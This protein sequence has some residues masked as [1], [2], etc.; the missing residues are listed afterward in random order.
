MSLFFFFTHSEIKAHPPSCLPW[1]DTGLEPSSNTKHCSCSKSKPLLKQ[2]HTWE[3]KAALVAELTG[4][5]TAG[6]RKA[7]HLIAGGHGKPP[8]LLVAKPRPGGPELRQ[9]EVQV[10]IWPQGVQWGLCINQKDS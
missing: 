5:G 9:V 6:M 1:G 2:S 10:R 7:L 4:V 8:A 3:H